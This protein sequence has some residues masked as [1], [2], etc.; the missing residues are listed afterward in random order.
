M[1]SLKKLTCNMTCKQTGMHALWYA[2]KKTSLWCVMHAVRHSSHN[3]HTVY[4]QNVPVSNIFTHQAIIVWYHE[5]LMS[6]FELSAKAK[7]R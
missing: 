2:C 3:M 7:G 5:V 1:C 4:D 6:W